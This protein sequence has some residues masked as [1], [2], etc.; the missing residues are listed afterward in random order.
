MD[1]SVK[2]SYVQFT[3]YA[4]EHVIKPKP[5]NWGTCLCMT[6]LNPELK[7]EA[8]RKNITTAVN[9]DMVKDQAHKEDVDN[10]IEQ[11]KTSGKTF[12]YL[13][14][15]KVKEKGTGAT[16]KA[17]TYHSKKVALAAGG[18]DFAKCVKNDF[19]KLY[20]HS[21]R[22]R[23]QYRR[24]AEIKNYV[25]DPQNQSKLLRIDWSENVDLYQTRQEMLQYYTTIYASVNVLMNKLREIQIDLYYASIANFV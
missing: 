21:I 19:E 2:S 3:R 22:F 5:E 10:L 1:E 17:T 15:T 24:I 7:L 6:C 12:K 8:I 25:Q 16:V 4:P 14:W 13:E 9:L 18:K 20:E 23:A 11:I